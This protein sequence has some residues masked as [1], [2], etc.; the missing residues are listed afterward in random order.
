[1][2]DAPWP[3]ASLGDLE[4]AALAQSNVR[5]GTRTFSKEISAWPCGASS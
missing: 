2:V 4:A 1:M 5:S 3:E